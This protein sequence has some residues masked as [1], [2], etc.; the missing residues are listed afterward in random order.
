MY[1]I[2]FFVALAIPIAIGSTVVI[3]QESPAFKHPKA[4]ITIMNRDAV[5][6]VH[7]LES[8]LTQEQLDAIELA[9][10]PPLDEAKRKE[11]A[12]RW[13]QDAFMAGWEDD[14]EIVRAIKTITKEEIVEIPKP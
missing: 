9:L 4:I 14:S 11:V 3:A 2:L 6:V 10:K 5:R 13:L 8:L 1:K 12:K 7:I